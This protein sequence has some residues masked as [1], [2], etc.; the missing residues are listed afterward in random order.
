MLLAQSSISETEATI[1]GLLVVASLVAIVARRV[2]LPYSVGLVLIGLLIGPIHVFV[3]VRLTSDVIFLIFLPPLLFDGAINLDLHELKRRRTQIATLAVLGTLVSAAF[4]ATPL[5]LLPG[6]TAGIAVLIAVI[7]APT[8]PVSVLATFKANPVDVG[9]RTLIEGESI[10]NDAFAIVL[11]SIAVEVAF[12]TTHPLTIGSALT[13]FGREVG[14]GL[15]VGFVVGLLAHRL[16]STLDDHLVEIMLSVT[17]AFATYLVASQL[18]GSGVIATVTAGLLLGNYGTHRSMAP[19]SRAI[20]AEFWEVIAFI[21]NSALF[22]MIG[23]EF[24]IKDLID[25]RTAAATGIAVVGMFVGRAVIAWGVLY[26]FTRVHEPGPDDRTVRCRIPGSWRSAVF[27]GG[28]RG[29]IPIA[30]I[31]G[32]GNKRVGGVNIVPLVFAV[33]LVSLITQGLTFKPW[34]KRIGL[35]V[36]V[37]NAK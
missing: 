3:H 16:M 32:V 12:P 21:A 35:I 29:S 20:M 2:H 28:L 11:Y 26:P 9:L 30:L 8:D 14:I 13:A 17:T 27:W 22:L 31:L 24:R 18:H 5:L 23:L 10:F 19:A 37:T 25:G 15:A 7:L 1:I 33:V 6:M 36:C 4:I 34:L